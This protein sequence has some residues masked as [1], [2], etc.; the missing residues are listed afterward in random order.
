MEDS[1]FLHKFALGVSDGV[2]GWSTFGITAADFSDSLMKHCKKVI[3][4]TLVKGGTNQSYTSSSLQDSILFDVDSDVLN[5]SNKSSSC[6]DSRVLSLDPITVT[7]KAYTQV[8]H[9]GSATAVV[10]VLKNDDLVCSNIGDSGFRLVRFDPSG[11]PFLMME[12]H[13]QQH[14]F[15]TPYQLCKLPTEKRISEGLSEMGYS[16]TQK[17]GLIG[18]FRKFAF[19]QDAPEAGK[20]YQMRVQEGDLLIL[21]S[22]GLFDNLFENEILDTLREIVKDEV[23]PKEIA[24]VLCQKAY[25]RSINT[26]EKT[27]FADK[28]NEA[29]KGNKIIVIFT[30]YELRLTENIGRKDRR[31]NSGSSVDTKEKVDGMRTERLII[32]D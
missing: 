14:D 25:K 12:S 29:N 16:A 3:D 23:R 4:D 7:R 5:D 13:E 20:V 6:N 30:N 18:K 26:K 2:G 8:H 27:P 28:Y 31:Y 21:G 17:E 10:C 15:N 32:K 19:C 1:Y 24:K 9:S 11:N 22:D